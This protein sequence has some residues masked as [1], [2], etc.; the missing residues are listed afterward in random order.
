M[1]NPGKFFLIFYG[2]LCAYCGKRESQQKSN[3]QTGI[4]LALKGVLKTTF[5]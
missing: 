5:P 3:L 1:H 2:A 4:S